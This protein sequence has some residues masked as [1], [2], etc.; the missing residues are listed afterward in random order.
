MKTATTDSIYLLFLALC[1]ATALSATLYVGQDQPFQTVQSAID[2]SVSGDIIIVSPGSYQENIDFLGKN[3]TVTSTNPDDR[4][5][6]ESTILN[7]GG[8]GS[9]VTFSNGEGPEAVLSGLTITGGYGTADP[10]LS[11]NAVFGGGIFCK[12]ASPTITKNIIMGNHGPLDESV[13]A[14]LGAGIACVESE[15]V[16]TSNIIKDNST[17]GAGAIVVYVCNPF[18]ANNLIYHNTATYIGGVYLAYGGRF[19]NNTMVGNSATAMGGHIAALG[20]ASA[21]HFV[22]E[23]NLICNAGEGGGIHVEGGQADYDAI[24]YNNVWNNA[25]GNY[26]NLPDQTGLNGNISLDPLC[27]GIEA[28]DFRLLAGSPCIDAGN[29]APVGGLLPVDF[30]GHSRP[31][32]GDYDGEAIVDI[33]A[34]EAEGT[35][36]PV[37]VVSTGKVSLAAFEGSDPSVKT[38]TI[39]NGGQ[40]VLHWTIEENC[41]WLEATP[42]SGS[43]TGPGDQTEVTVS[44]HAAGMS[45]GSYECTF[46]IVASDALNTPK[47]ISVSLYISHEG[48]IVVPFSFPTIQEAI[49]NV[50]PGDTIIVTPGLYR[51][52]I[53][54]G[55][56]NFVLTSVNPADWENVKST[57]IRGLGTGPV[58]TFE[59]SEL[60]ACLLQGFTIEGGN[61]PYPGGGGITGTGATSLATIRHCIIQNNATTDYGGGI[62]GC[63]GLISNCIVR[64]NVAKNGGGLSWCDGIVKN[65][66]VVNN[67][68][69]TA[70]NAIHRCNGSILNGTIVSDKNLAISQVDSCA[71]SFSNC[72]LYGQNNIASNFTG[73]VT[74]CCFAGAESIS[75]I[76]ADPLFVNPAHKDYHLSAE[77]ACIN[78]GAPDY[79]SESGETDIDDQMRVLSGRIDM[80]ADEFEGYF[81]PRVN[82]GPD[83]SFVEIPA[84]V[85]LQGQ[86]TLSYTTENTFQWHQVSGPDVSLDNSDTLTALF[87][88]TEYGI[89]VFELI[90]S[91]S[92]GPGKPDQVGILI[93]NTMPV[94]SIPE[95]HYISDAYDTIN[96]SNCCF[97]PDGFGEL[98]LNFNQVS[99]PYPLRIYSNGDVTGIVSTDAIQEF[100]FDASVSDGQLNSEAHRIKIIVTPN[101]YSRQNTWGYDNRLVLENQSFNPSLPTIVYLGGGDGRDG[102]GSP[103]GFPWNQNANVLY[104]EEYAN[105]PPNNSPNYKS[106]AA[107]LVSYLSSVA[108]EYNKLIQM[109]GFST[110][111]TACLDIANQI[112]RDYAN[113]YSDFR[114]AINRVSTLDIQTTYSGQ[115]QSLLDNLLAN[116]PENGEPCWVDNYKADGKYLNGALNIIFPGGSHG[117]PVNWFFD[118]SYDL[119]NINWD[120]TITDLYNGGITAGWFISVCGPMANLNFSGETGTFFFQW[121]GNYDGTNPVVGHLR[122]YSASYTGKLLQPITLVGPEDGAMIGPEGAPLSCLKSNRAI[123]YQLLFGDHPAEVTHLI[124]ETPEPPSLVITQ[125]PFSHT[126]WTVKAFD[127]FGNSIHADP[128]C[129]RSESVQASVRNTS[130]EK[131][132]AYI[133]FAID[134]A[135][136]GE[137]IVVSPGLHRED[138]RF[139]G[140]NVI[141]TS[142]DPADWDIVESTIIQELGAGPVV[143][144]QGSELPACVLQGFTIEG[145][146]APYPGGGG[147][148][149][150]GATSLATISHCIIQNNTTTDYGGGI[151]GCKGL[152][153]NC[154]VRNNGAKNGGGLS[155]CD[156]MIKNCLIVNNTATT[157]GNAVYRCNG[158]ILNCTIVSDN[159]L[160][161]SQINS[162]T[163][164]FTNCILDGQNN[165]F[166]ACTGAVTYSCCPSAGIGNISANPLFTDPANGDYHLKSKGWSW[167]T[168]ARQ[169]TWDDQTSPCID[170]GHPGMLPG[171]EPITLEVDPLN[172]WGKNIRIN[173]G[174]YG[175]TVEASMAPPGW[176]LLCDLTNDGRVNLADLSHLA[177]NWLKE[178]DNLPGDVSRDGWVQTEDLILFAQEWLT[179][180]TRS[181]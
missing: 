83:Q 128:I 7:A 3:I 70:G 120:G 41:S 173:M 57:I 143:K 59:G 98:V 159:N 105:N 4:A 22:I 63:K 167:D 172:R 115:A 71:G 111:T 158:Q 69:T 78:A 99:G 12:S 166:N 74:Y 154:I 152:I 162:C 2:A 181:E 179:E 32:D 107:M 9:T 29:N 67:T 11:S 104:F 175:G 87:T 55:G 110:G 40:D 122:Q 134:E 54:F 39:A 125:L 132:Y 108:P 161:V 149:G 144:F 136:D 66:W 44:V 60:P 165:V 68:A 48:E 138:I 124:S 58:V 164:S 51:E 180:A 80:G 106:C 171:D 113:H 20:D 151:G 50:L 85:T 61:A 145:G 21:G 81:P 112:N 33:G 77:S 31:L 10:D 178:K 82:A 160:A 97:D 45:P 140:K 174:A 42:L 43:S 141:L 38:F 1:T 13:L 118:A 170:A 18:I 27:L 146:N 24:G 62:A 142:V 75:N 102:G 76:S 135:M 64:N 72:I 79:L 116:K 130:T 157:A 88:P 53:H 56:K 150:T 100:V 117:D 16:I 6:V 156:G 37:I 65:C 92:T 26:D 96:I 133:Q 109:A 126:Y 169:W 114:Y 47:T 123:K 153:S 17:Y 73:T 46:D 95:T 148:I 25:G 131:T 28:G 89:Y 94:L 5:I 147:I 19:I 86:L 155:W 23:N 15:A 177:E 34:F 176:A 129:I 103:L 127:E 36:N 49:D 8:S 139:N 84:T 52:N 93:G 101:V 168:A 163:G 14:G 119:S 30:G 91:D 35:T 90:A 137:E 121:S